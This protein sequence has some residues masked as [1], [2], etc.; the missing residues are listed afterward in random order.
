MNILVTNDDG[1]S[2]G[3]RLLLQVA[4]QFGK[5]FAI[6]PN[7]Q[8]SAVSGALTLHK[9][10]RIHQIREQFHTINGTPSDC[11][12]FGLHSKEFPK[13]DLVLSGINWG[14]NTGVSTLL[15]S[16]TVAACWQAALKRVPAIAFSMH[17]KEGEDWHH[18]ET[19]GDETVMA[20]VIATIIKELKPKLAPGKFFNVNLP[21]KEHLANAKIVY[22][23]NFQ[24]DRYDVE[25]EKRLDPDDHPY[26]WIVG[27]P[28]K[29]EKGTDVHEV[30]VGKNI[31][32]SEVSIDT[33]S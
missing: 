24:R 4:T 13:P 31:V 14:D 10:I 27:V 1:D 32:I 9:P 11:V 17:R 19:W 15:G 2:H 30:I 23:Q 8:R 12:L 25:I 3:S 29:I 7:R 6:V 26:Y 5:A 16:G 21:R 22:T 18:K 33:L 20:R 28:N